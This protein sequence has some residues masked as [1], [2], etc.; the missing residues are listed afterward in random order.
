MEA[1]R[2]TDDLGDPRVALA[3]ERTFLAWVRTGLAMMGFGF[4]VSRFAVF[5]ND[6]VREESIVAMPATFTPSVWIGVMLV[7]AGVVVLAGAAVRYRHHLA[8]L[9]GTT[10]ATFLRPTFG[11]TVAVI[12]CLIGITTVVVLIARLS[13]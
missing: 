4:V 13:G 9:R 1:Q 12:L 11:L 5:L 3:V 8:L 7:V 6:L 10:S 2:N